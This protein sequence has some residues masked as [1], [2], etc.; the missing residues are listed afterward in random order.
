MIVFRAV[1]C[2]EPMA[3][4]GDHYVPLERPDNDRFFSKLRSL[5]ASDPPGVHQFIEHADWGFVSVEQPVVTI[6]EL[7]PGETA[8]E[9][10][11][12]WR[13]SDL[14][15]EK[16][17]P[18]CTVA[19]RNDVELIGEGFVLVAADGSK[20]CDEGAIWEARPGLALLH[21]EHGLGA[22]MDHLSYTLYARDSD[23]RWARRP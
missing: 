12:G 2:R 5:D 22:S 18:K 11:L 16:P 20:D 13:P 9:F 3:L 8:Q 1:T 17:L 15:H 19:P 14:H 6:A 4:D 21:Y 10:A 23:G 7:S